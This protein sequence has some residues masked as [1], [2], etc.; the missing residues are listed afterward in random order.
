MWWLV[1]IALAVPI[2]P[3]LVAGPWIESWISSALAA[4]AGRPLA[5][6]IAV[7]VALASDILL[8]VPGSAVATLAG[9]TLGPAT[10]VFCVWSGLMLSAALGFEATRRFGRPMAERLC[11]PAELAAHA[12]RFRHWGAAGLVLTRPVP[13][14]ADACILWAGL[15]EFPRRRFYT[16]MAFANMAVAVVFVILGWISSR[17][18]FTGLGLLISVLV[19]LL[20]AVLL[21]RRTSAFAG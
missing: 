8:P 6:A 3:F 21:C 7:V 18:E 9:Q 19:P 1:G 11:P 17:G 5:T 16:A 12:E 20:L 14:L 4:L 15:Q 2:A 10:A 13:I